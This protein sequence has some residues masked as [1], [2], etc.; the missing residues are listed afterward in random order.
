VSRITRRTPLLTRSTSFEPHPTRIALAAAALVSAFAAPAFAQSAEPRPADTAASAPAGVALQPIKVRGAATG[1]ATSEGSRSFANRSASVV[2][3]GGDLREIPQPVTV[4]TRQLID[5]RKLV[6]FQEVMQNTPGVSVDYTDSERVTF[7]SRGYQIDALQVDGITINQGG[8]G[9][10]QP[11]TAVLDRVEI[12]RGSSGMIRGSGNP[13][14]VVNM[15]RKR[16]TREFQASGA[17]TVGSWERR[18]IE[19]DVSGALNEAGTLRGRAVGVYDDKDFFQKIKQEEKQVFYGVLEA[20]LTPSTL[21]TASLQY[22]AVEANGSWGNLPVNFDGSSLDLPRDTY[23]GADWNRWDRYN[24]QAF[25]EL[26]HRFDNAWTVKATGSQTRLRLEDNGFRQTYFDRVSTAASPN[27]DPTNPYMMR[28]S[29]AAYT[30]AQSDQSAFNLTA[31]G[32]F[33]LLGRKHK[34]VVGAEML[35]TKAIDSWGVGTQNPIWVDIRNWNPQTSYPDPHLVISTGGALAAVTRQEAA[36]A[37]ANFS[38]TDPLTVMV[39][40]RV[41]WWDTYS[42]T[43]AYGVNREVTP[44]LGAVY[45]IN[46]QISAYSS[47]TEIFAPQN[48]KDSAGNILDPVRGEDYELGLKG[49]FFDGKLNASASLFRINNV[50][51]QVED[52][53]SPTPCTPYYTT[54]YCRMNGG[55][56]RS[57]GLEIEV[58]GEVARGWQVMG[59]YTNTR[60]RILH[61]ASAATVGT[62]LRTNDPRQQFKLFTSYRLGGVLEGL[63]VGGGTQIQSDTF[64]T[65]GALTARQPGYAIYNGMLAYRFNANYS[66]QLNANNL[67]DKVYYKKVSPTGISTYYGDPRNFMLTLR[68][69]L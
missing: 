41:S 34:L 52:T 12:L 19:L 61:A 21:L 5:E 4:L 37:T 42:P 48:F 32:P 56:T 38:V 8:S 3:G 2:K 45:A 54:G 24:V 51:A 22:S 31:D 36:Y 23:L 57:E 55:K 20:D 40:T 27:P 25:A 58:A 39:G 30:G 1:D 69:S 62:P 68:A 7:F 10:V 66:L 35:R 50:G 46:D 59:G 60:T 6:D 43:I 11:D 26:K 33:E 49:E 18:R 64:V 14:A 47:Y 53:S 67:F 29:S 28:V 63:T 13:S 15:V 17:V 9:F 65:S 44:Y 16:P